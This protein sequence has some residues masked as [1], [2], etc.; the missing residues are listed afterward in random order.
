MKYRLNLKDYDVEQ[1]VFEVVDDE[2]KQVSKNI[3]VEVKKELYQIL[4]LPGVYKDGIETCDGVALAIV[5]KDCEE[6]H[7]DI[8]AK[9]LEIL[10]RIFDKLIAQEHKPQIGQ[11][12]M[13][14][15]RYI[16]LIQRVFQAPEVAE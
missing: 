2:R 13:G 15:E 14:G 6:D 16:E 9:E 3:P 12:A 4:R 5:I 11:M 10:K 7:L 8:E 1:M